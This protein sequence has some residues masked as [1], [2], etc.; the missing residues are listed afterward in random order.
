ME[1]TEEEIKGMFSQIGI[2]KKMIRIQKTVCAMITIYLA[3]A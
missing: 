1:L 2:V 3:D